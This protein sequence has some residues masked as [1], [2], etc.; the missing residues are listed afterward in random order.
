MAAFKKDC[1]IGVVL[2]EEDVKNVTLK[3][4]EKADQSSKKF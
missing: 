1:G 3:C 2:S 4:I